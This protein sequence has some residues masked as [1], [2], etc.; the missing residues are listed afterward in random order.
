MPK[1]VEVRVLSAAHF[2]LHLFMWLFLFLFLAK[3]A[4]A[5]NSTELYIQYRTD[6]LYQ[7]D[8]YQQNY[9]DYLNKKNVYL[10]YGTTSSEQDK[11]NATKTLFLSRNS[12]LKAYLMT[13]RVNLDQYAGFSSNTTDIQAKLQDL[14]K[15][16]DTQ[17]Q[18]I[19]NLNSSAGLAN[20][21]KTFN[22]QYVSIQTMSYTAII[23]S[24]IN[25]RLAILDQAKKLADNAQ[26]NW[27]DSY[28]T[29]SNQIKTLLQSA[30]DTT[31]KNQREDQYTD[32]YPEA[33]TYL[34]QSDSHLKSL[35]ADLKSYLIKSA[36]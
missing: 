23:Q 32:F 9:T 31:Q 10:Q 8:Q 2:L 34:D 18:V 13:L 4:F 29:Q 22:T 6:Y 7:R 16:L 33:K 19:P 25:L 15:W 3:S 30:Y 27:S 26:I 1:G 11:I 17:N 28:N 5:Q 35:I 21:A 14:E 24:Q 12:L 20:W 36:N